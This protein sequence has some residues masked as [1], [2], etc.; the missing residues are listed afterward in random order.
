[1][2]QE[3]RGDLVDIVDWQTKKF[4]KRLR[5]L[6][7]DIDKKLQGRLKLDTTAGIGFSIAHKPS[8]EWDDTEKHAVQQMKRFY[9][10]YF[11]TDS[12]I[13]ENFDGLANLDT[14]KK[15]YLDGVFMANKDTIIKEKIQDFFQKNKGE[16]VST[17][18]DIEKSFNLRFEQLNESTIAEI[19]KQ[20]EI[21][22][23]LFENVKKKFATIFNS[24]GISLQSEIKSI[25]NDIL[26]EEIRDIPTENIEKYV[27]CKGLLWGHN[28]VFVEYRQVNTQRLNKEILDAVDKYSRAW[29]NRWKKIFEDAKKEMA[30]KLNDV[31][32]DVE[33]QIRSTSFNDAYYRVL[34]DETLDK[35][36][37]NKELSIEEIIKGYKRQGEDI[38]KKQL[39]ISGTRDK[40][41]G[42][43]DN[44]IE[45][46]FNLHIRQLEKEF[47]VL[48]DSIIED[49]K[50]EVDKNLK[51]ALSLVEEMK[52]SFA[53]NLQKEGDEYLVSLEK[54]LKEKTVT[55]DKVKSIITCIGELKTLYT[56]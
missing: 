36:R 22:K 23:A 17:L 18:N 25:A 37:I 56:V 6:S 1:M 27:T 21:Q 49:V 50:N 44:Y 47:R 20:K 30:S 28:N 51:S 9:P 52:K 34:I 31:I 29:N 16:V 42:E 2:K 54:D 40:Q 24:W 26:F 45:W 53:D 7:G 35:M 39:D 13:K 38:A 33:K 48:A 32:C 5:E 8:S 3:G 14:I 43:L 41:E 15:E 55:L 10:D 19:Q 4:K 12:D 11:A 46:R